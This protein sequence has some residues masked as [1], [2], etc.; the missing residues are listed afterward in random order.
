MASTRAHLERAPFAYFEA[1][2]RKDLD[3]SLAFFADDA[4][5]TIQTAHT[6][7]NGIDEIAGMFRGFFS[8][9]SVIVHNIRN[10]V[11][12]ETAG[13]AS[14]EQ[15]VPL[16]AADGSPVNLVTCNFFTYGP[17]GR[18]TRVIVWMDGASPLVGE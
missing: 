5:F 15:V 9:F 3:A 7:Y 17:D 18:F 2:D 8:D 16:V 13:K 12:D 6:V 10:I 1:V 4:T 11:V 14:T